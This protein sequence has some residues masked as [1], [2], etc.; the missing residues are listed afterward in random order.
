MKQKEI[1]IWFCS[2]PK[3]C[4][5]NEAKRVTVVEQQCSPASE[6]PCGLPL[7]LKSRHR[8]VSTTHEILKL[9]CNFSQVLYLQL[10]V[11]FKS[12]TSAPFVHCQVLRHIFSRW[13]LSLHEAP[14]EHTQEAKGKT[15]MCIY[16]AHHSRLCIWCQGKYLAVGCTNWQY[17]DFSRGK[18][19][20]S[21]DAKNSSE[22]SLKKTLPLHFLSVLTRLCICKRLRTQILS[23]LQISC[24][25]EKLHSRRPNGDFFML[26]RDNTWPHYPVITQENLQ[27]LQISYFQRYNSSRNW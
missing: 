2:L 15:C 5:E 26:F 1:Y 7:W 27:T 14:R 17:W 24:N 9:L 4:N 16:V 10:P 8:K 3:N 25:L 11:L 13:K 21:E 19:F 20:L 12:L 23:W 22:V 18:V 6:M